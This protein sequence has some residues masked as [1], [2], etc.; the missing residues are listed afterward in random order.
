MNWD[1]DELVKELLETLE[2]RDTLH[3]II[4]TLK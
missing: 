2:E 3:A 4:T 1:D